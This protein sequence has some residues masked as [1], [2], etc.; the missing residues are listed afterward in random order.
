M[1]HIW[2]LRNDVPH[3]E[4]FYVEDTALHMIKWE[5][6]RRTEDK[7]VTN[8]VQNKLLCCLANYPNGPQIFLFLTLLFM[9][10][11]KLIVFPM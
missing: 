8:S 2:R 4:K 3:Q 9:L 1:Y 10:W 11:V 7:G 6:K 5:V